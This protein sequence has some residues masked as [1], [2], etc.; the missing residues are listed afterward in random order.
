MIDEVFTINQERLVRS[1]TPR[2]GDPYQHACDFETFEEVLHTIDKFGDDAFVYEQ[3][4]AATDL[5]FSQVAT[6]FAF[7]KEQGVI[8]D[9]GFRRQKR[10][11]DCVHL[12]GMIEWCALTIRAN[13]EIHKGE[14]L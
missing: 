2:R 14:R 8:V 9:A 4:Q 7:L 1:V 12:D 5:P 11:T 13:T 6:A 10:A 3:V